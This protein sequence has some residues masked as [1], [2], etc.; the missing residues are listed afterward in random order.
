MKS[1]DFAVN[2]GDM[3]RGPDDGNAVVA[4]PLHKFVRLQ[5]A[6]VDDVG[7]DAFPGATFRLK[8][9]SAQGFET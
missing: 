9:P 7:P 6:V 1:L 4:T 2:F 8:L 3:G 5:L